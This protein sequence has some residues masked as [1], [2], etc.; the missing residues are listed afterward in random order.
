MG[1]QRIL[2]SEVRSRVLRVERLGIPAMDCAAAAA[3]A[4]EQRPCVRQKGDGPDRRAGARALR[5]IERERRS[6]IANELSALA[7]AMRSLRAP[8]PDW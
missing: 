7:A 1:R 6:M 8:S 5:R 2:G 4:A 3:A